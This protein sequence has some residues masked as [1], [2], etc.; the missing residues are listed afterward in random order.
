MFCSHSWQDW[1][2]HLRNNRNEFQKWVVHENSLYT[3]LKYTN[4][5]YTEMQYINKY[6]TNYH[7]QKNQSIKQEGKQFVKGTNKRWFCNIPKRDT[8]QPVICLRF[9]LK[10]M[11]IDC[12]QPNYNWLSLLALLWAK[13]KLTILTNDFSRVLKA[14]VNSFCQMRDNCLLHPYAVLT[15]VL[16]EAWLWSGISK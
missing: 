9:P 11:G 14:L 15:Y 13:Q 6:V 16:I 2:Q 7:V 1:N 3:T 5:T 10:H 4:I 12:G 8:V